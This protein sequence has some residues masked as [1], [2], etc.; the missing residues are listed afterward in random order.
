[1]L[2]LLFRRPSWLLVLCVACGPDEAPDPSTRIEENC[3]DLCLQV[4]C[5]SSTTEYPPNFFADCV[6]KCER[7]HRSAEDISDACAD[8]DDAFIECLAD[9]TCPEFMDWSMNGETCT[10]EESRYT[11]HCPDLPFSFG[12]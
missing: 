6:Q 9:S 2:A 1:M 3:S 4:Q 10:I 11:E 7:H 8:A 5:S 12:L